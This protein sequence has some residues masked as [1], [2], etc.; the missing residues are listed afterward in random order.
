[1]IRTSMVGGISFVGM[2][3]FI[4]CFDCVTAI[5]NCSLKMI[6][7]HFFDFFIK[8]LLDFFYQCVFNLQIWKTVWQEVTP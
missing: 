6:F 4:L 7:P 2:N 1:M 5:P 3:S 8:E